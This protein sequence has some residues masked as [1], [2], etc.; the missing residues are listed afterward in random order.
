MKEY[1][2][3]ELSELFRE[4]GFSEVRAYFKFKKFRFFWPDYVIRI[5]EYC[6]GKL[7]FKLRKKLTGN[8]LVG[9]MLSVNVVGK[10]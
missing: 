1:T 9:T 6:L 10:K 7:S 5:F 4:T 3:T 8:V 2:I